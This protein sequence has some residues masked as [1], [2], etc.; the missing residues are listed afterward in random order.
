MEQYEDPA[1]TNF[2]SYLRIRTD[3][4]VPDYAAATRFL[5]SQAESL[6]LQYS[7]T[8]CSPGKP[9]VVITWPGTNHNISSI[10][11]NSHTD[12]SR[13][14]VMPVLIITMF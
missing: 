8:E 4:P 12:V 1:V 3:H 14:V 10:L 2:R 9:V 11:L 6:G 13:Q 7:C 5:L